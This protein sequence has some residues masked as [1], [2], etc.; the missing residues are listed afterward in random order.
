MYRAALLTVSEHPVGLLPLHRRSGG[1]RRR[2]VLIVLQATSFIHSR[3]YKLFFG[4]FT[5]IIFMY[6]AVVSILYKISDIIYYL[7]KYIIVSQI[8]WIIIFGFASTLTIQC[9]YKVLQNCPVNM[10]SLTNFVSIH[11]SKSSSSSAT[12]PN[13]LHQVP[14]NQII[15]IKCH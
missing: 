15:F 3:I 6:Q 8:S 2:E 7:Y 14:L 10:T 4:D 9:M 1:R 13:H 12:K 5:K 11:K